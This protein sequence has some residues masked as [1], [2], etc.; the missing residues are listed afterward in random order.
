[1]ANQNI[2]QQETTHFPLEGMDKGEEKDW[3]R[4]LFKWNFFFHL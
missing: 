3:G 4:Q 1:M 2:D